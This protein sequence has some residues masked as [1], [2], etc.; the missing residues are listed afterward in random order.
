MATIL[1]LLPLSALAH[2]RG[3]DPGTP[4]PRACRS[5][6][7]TERLEIAAAARGDTTPTVTRI[8]PDQFQNLQSEKTAHA[9]AHTLQ[10]Q[11]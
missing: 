6:Q 11:K 1:H 8:G 10:R 4:E 3:Y 9:L 7:D 2:D 5:A